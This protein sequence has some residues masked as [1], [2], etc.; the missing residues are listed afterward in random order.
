MNAMHTSP[1]TQIKRGLRIKDLR[2]ERELSQY[3]CAPLLNMSRTYLADLECGRRNVSLA[4]L[5]AI[6]DGFGITLEE[7][8]K[9]V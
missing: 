5:S 2:E 7:L 1:E 3:A 9:G 4:R 6:A 8:F